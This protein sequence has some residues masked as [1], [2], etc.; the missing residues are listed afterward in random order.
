MS[1]AQ[2]FET[3]LCG[4]LDELAESIAATPTEEL[5][6][7]ELLKNNGAPVN[8][9]R[10]AARVRDKFQIALD[11]QRFD[12]ALGVPGFE[13]GF[14]V[15]KRV[16]A[17][18]TIKSSRALPFLSATTSVGS[19]S[20]NPAFETLTTMV[21]D[22]AEHQSQVPLRLAVLGDIGA[23]KRTLTAAI[24]RVFS[25]RSSQFQSNTEAAKR[26]FRNREEGVWR[27]ATTYSTQRHT[28]LHANLP[29]S[30]ESLALDQGDDL[31][32]ADVVI[33]VVSAADA[34]R[35]TIEGFRN[36]LRRARLTN[37]VLFLNK[38]GV[39]PSSRVEWIE[40]E[41]QLLPGAKAIPLI[42]GSAVSALEGQ[43]TSVLQLVAAL[44]SRLAMRA[45]VTP[46]QG[47]PVDA[48]A[49]RG[50]EVASKA[51]RK[52][53]VP[54]PWKAACAGS[55]WLGK[56]AIT[57]VH[58][59]GRLLGTVPGPAAARL[60]LVSPVV[61]SSFVA[62][63]F[64]G[65]SFRSDLGVASKTHQEALTAVVGFSSPGDERTAGQ[66]QKMLAAE[67]TPSDPV[68]VAARDRLPTRD[69]GLGRKTESPAAEGALSPVNPS[70]E[71]TVDSGKSTAT[72]DV[73]TSVRD[74][75]PPL[76]K[77][78]T[79]RLE[80][81]SIDRMATHQASVA[82]E[83]TD[84]RDPSPE[85]R[86]GVWDEADRQLFDTQVTTNKASIDLPVDS[87]ERHYTLEVTCT[88][89]AGNSSSRIASLAVPS[90]SWHVEQWWM[91]SLQ[92]DPNKALDE[93]KGQMW[94]RP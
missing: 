75:T 43:E 32:K 29:G 17:N 16:G 73:H 50:A 15:E 76:I 78:L 9:H 94:K 93:S 39:A 25:S 18:E 81:W 7:E 71:L 90:S 35:K 84:H 69:A 3:Q 58:A 74:K 55:R 52:V 64:V 79:T 53:L 80:S 23:G 77:V 83:A 6:F 33:L 8:L 63:M 92:E 65:T 48:D 66:N 36:L 57:L 11:Q 21:D 56:A 41:L 85:C 62:S 27:N 14:S 24:K 46:A 86:I 44:E 31:A 88:D 45:A 67:K 51:E 42:K 60:L 72:D 89:T 34:T 40:Q 82:V 87:N 26:W 12:A 70:V 54:G 37:V 61:V 38:I 68:S 2:I 13:A 19:T 22:A 30:L 20:S 91:G 10:V 28:Y 1:E 4:V 47:V 5:D 49:A 59:I